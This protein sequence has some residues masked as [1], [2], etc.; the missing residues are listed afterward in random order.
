[1]KRLALGRGLDALIPEKGGVVVEDIDVHRID[2]SPFQPRQSIPDAALD[3][4][5][6]S[7]RETGLLQPIIVRRR[8]E[9]Y[10]IVAGERRW[11]AAIRAGWSTIP[12]IVR[13]VSDETSLLIA[14]I[15]NI[16]RQD[17]NPVEEAMAYQTMVREF[18]LTQEEVAQRVGKPRATVANYL[19]LLKLPEPV[20]Q[21]LA[22]GTLTMGHAKVLLA[23]NDPTEQIHLAERVVQ[24]GWTVRQLERWIQGRR[25]TQPRQRALLDPDWQIVAERLQTALG[26]QVRLRPRGE[27]GVVV[28]LYFADWQGVDEFYR[29][30]I[31]STMD[32]P[33]QA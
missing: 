26:A 28:Q 13:D 32:E 17:L 15:E 30:V 19:R 10:E 6:Q 29:R 21:R 7:L 14:L 27:R 20:L 25:T 33:V 5:A 8:G 31:S 4:L 11:R 9:R 22:E 23:L 2:P 16:Q 1:M 24:E 12:A 3:E 18:H